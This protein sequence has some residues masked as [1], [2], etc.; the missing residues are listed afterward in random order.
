MLVYNQTLSRYSFL[1]VGLN[2]IV[3]VNVKLLGLRV[4]Q[5]ITADT[6]FPLDNGLQV[7]P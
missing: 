3:L 1:K 4:A 5:V 6:K 7:L 2:V